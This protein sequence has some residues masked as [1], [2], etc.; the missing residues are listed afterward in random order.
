MTGTGRLL[1]QQKWKAAVRTASWPRSRQASRTD[2]HLTFAPRDRLPRSPAAA[3]AAQKLGPRGRTRAAERGRRSRHTRLPR[4]VPT[5]HPAGARSPPPPSTT[6]PRRPPSGSSP[7]PCWRR[8]ATI[9]TRDAHIAE[10]PLHRC[11]P[12]YS[13]LRIASCHY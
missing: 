6:R 7:K 2:Q 8:P 3:A 12:G 13:A 9:W 5:R 11:G 1:P 4:S 10:S